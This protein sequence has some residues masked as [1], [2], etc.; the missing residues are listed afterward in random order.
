MLVLPHIGMQ[1][2]LERGEAIRLAIEVDDW[3]RIVP[4]LQVTISLG[5]ASADETQSWEA[6][7]AL[8]DQRM[9]RAK[10]SG[11]NRICGPEGTG[12]PAGIADV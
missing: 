4:G 7:V 6:L 3:A 12:S 2:M 10:N 5:L 11:R 9:Y 1:Q 8:A